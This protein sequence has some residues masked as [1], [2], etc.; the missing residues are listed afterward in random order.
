MIG[1]SSCSPLRTSR[2][3]EG[4]GWPSS[5]AGAFRLQRRRL[6]SSN[7]NPDTSEVGIT[8]VEKLENTGV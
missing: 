8:L 1:G 5:T 2:S 3:R 7:I 6:P 4:A